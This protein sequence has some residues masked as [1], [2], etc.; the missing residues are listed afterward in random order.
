LDFQLP[1]WP[2]Q[3]LGFSVAERSVARYLRRMIR[4]GDPDQKWLAF[5]CAIIAK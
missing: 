1:V 5:L 2:L 3:K 4:R